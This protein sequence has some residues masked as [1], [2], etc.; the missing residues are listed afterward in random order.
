MRRTP[1][2]APAPHAAPSAALRAPEGA[3]AGG[4][5]SYD[6][7]RYDTFRHYEEEELLAALL[8]GKPESLFDEEG[9][10]PTR[11][12]KR[13]WDKLGAGN[14]AALIEHIGAAA[15]ACKGAEHADDLASL[16][17]ATSKWAR[18]R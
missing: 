10:I 13:L 4:L 3:R 18:Q 17:A 16:V 5:R 9:V 15:D 7:T 14:K 6:A 11:R 1:A 8:T 2:A 12:I